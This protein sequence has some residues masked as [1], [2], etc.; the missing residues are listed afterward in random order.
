MNY[1]VKKLLIIKEDQEPEFYGDPETYSSH[2]DY[3]KDYIMENYDSK[4]YIQKWK[5]AGSPN[6]L[7][8]A[9]SLFK[10]IIISMNIFDKYGRCS[11]TCIISIP[12]EIS[13]ELQESFRKMTPFFSQFDNII[14]CKQVVVTDKDGFTYLEDESIDLDYCKT[15]EDKIETII[16]NTSKVKRK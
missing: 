16:K 6:Q 1:P 15:T 3:L 11:D 12:S 8:G 5:R 7:A 2:I 14:A 9:L 4:D 13:E 10:N